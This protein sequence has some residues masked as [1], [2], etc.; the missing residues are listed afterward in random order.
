MILP[1]P[2]FDPMFADD[3]VPFREKMI[4][5]IQREFSDLLGADARFLE[6]EGGLDILLRI[7]QARRSEKTPLRFSAC[8]VRTAA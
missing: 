2:E 1:T 5:C 3:G 4:R 6:S 8:P 7:A